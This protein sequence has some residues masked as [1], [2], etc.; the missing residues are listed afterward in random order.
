MKTKLLNELRTQLK[1]SENELREI[2]DARFERND[3]LMKIHK[4][5]LEQKTKIE[6]AERELRAARKAMIQKIN[7]RDFVSIFEV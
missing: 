6:R 1:Q 3:A 2:I 5:I 7:N 4:F